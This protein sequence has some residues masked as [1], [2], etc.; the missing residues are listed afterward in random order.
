MA[1]LPEPHSGLVIAYSYLWESEYRAG[2]EEGSKDRPCAVV[3][4]TRTEDGDIVV[5]VA[6]ITHRQPAD[7]SHGVELPSDVKRRLRLD[8]TRSWII[9]TELN[10]FVW[11]GPDLRPV[12]R[13]M[14]G[15]FAYGVLPR[16][17]MLRIFQLLIRLR[18][19]RRPV[20]VVR[21]S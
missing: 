13:S 10:R 11:P 14:P 8:D 19:E 20:I 18:T 15:Q 7:L 5:T 9:C 12:S 16:S 6:P 21:S 17:I 1:R 4:A 2:R 3:I